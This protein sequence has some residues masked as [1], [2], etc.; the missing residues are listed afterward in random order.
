MA[1][2]QGKEIIS[3]GHLRS[4]LSSALPTN[5]EQLLPSVKDNLRVEGPYEYGM[6]YIGQRG[7]TV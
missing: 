7:R 5:T 6:F 3:W 1:L 4:K 2:H